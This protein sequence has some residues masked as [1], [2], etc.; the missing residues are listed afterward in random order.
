MNYSKKYRKTV[1]QEFYLGLW[2]NYRESWSEDEFPTWQFIKNF[3]RK[4]EVMS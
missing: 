1:I 2:I 3:L 4:E